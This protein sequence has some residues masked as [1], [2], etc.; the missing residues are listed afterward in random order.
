MIMPSKHVRSDRALI[1]VGA[2]LIGLLREPMTVSR[3]WNEL[4]KRR[5][6]ETPNAPISY[7]WFVLALDMLFIMGAVQ[8][9]HGIILR[10]EA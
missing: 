2:E 1:G 5:T 4:R 9:K 8:I 10:V 7:S 6:L 3:L